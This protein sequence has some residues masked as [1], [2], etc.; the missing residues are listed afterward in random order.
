M[1][2][3]QIIID[4]LLLEDEE[5]FDFA[6]VDNPPGQPDPYEIW[7]RNYRPITNKF[8]PEG[9]FDGTMFETYGKEYEFVRAAKP[10][11]VWT[12]LT[13]DNNELIIVPGAHFINR[14]GYFIT[15]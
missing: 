7:L 1:D 6:E 2:K 9:P 5:D 11:H 12:Y 15:E 3:T 8:E 4:S 14:I 13:G 10:Q